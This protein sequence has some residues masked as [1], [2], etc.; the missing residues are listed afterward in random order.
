[1]SACWT[2]TF[3][4]S[5]RGCEGCSRAS[6]PGHCM[7]ALQSIRAL[8]AKIVRTNCDELSCEYFYPKICQA[9]HMIPP[10]ATANASVRTQ[11]IP[12][13]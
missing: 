6:H 5:A 2:L 9:I 10:Q 13:A 4:F 12:A 11:G 3:G 8:S 1:M 7:R